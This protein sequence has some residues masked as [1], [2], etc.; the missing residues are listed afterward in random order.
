MRST[1]TA[2]SAATPTKR[3]TSRLDQR[4]GKATTAA[5]KSKLTSMASQFFATVSEVRPTMSLPTTRTPSSTR[6]STPPA[7]RA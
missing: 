1:L 5:A 2:V 7:S 4:A 6:R 3:P